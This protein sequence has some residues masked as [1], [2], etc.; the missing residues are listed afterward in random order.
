MAAYHGEHASEH[1]V[2]LMA[3]RRVRCLEL[4]VVAWLGLGLG[5]ALG[6]RGG[7]WGVKGVGQGSP[8]GFSKRDGMKGSG[9]G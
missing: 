3:R 2:A 7:A 5:V 8:L 9:S 1:Q 4:G 6:V